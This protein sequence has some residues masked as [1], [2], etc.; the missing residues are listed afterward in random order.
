MIV[1]L[2]A[3]VVLATILMCHSVL[4]TYHGYASE[5]CSGDIIRFESWKD[6]TESVCPK[7]RSY[8]W[9]KDESELKDLRC[10]AMHSMEN[11]TVTADPL[12]LDEILFE[13]PDWFFDTGYAW[14]PNWKWSIEDAESR[15]H[16]FEQCLRSKITDLLTD[17]KRIGLMSKDLRATLEKIDEAT[18]DLV[19]GRPGGMGIGGFYSYDPPTIHI[20]VFGIIYGYRTS[21]LSPTALLVQI[22]LHEMF[23]A[24]RRQGG[25]AE[26]D[27]DSEE[28]AVWGLTHEAYLLLFGGKEPPQSDEE[29]RNNGQFD[30][31]KDSLTGSDLCQ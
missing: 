13:P 20:N 30:K 19:V 21:R 12:S 18:Y 25:L 23:H 17:K 16:D 6:L 22:I 27:R 14:S 3:T 4:A 15:V 8:K 11:L 1:I 7:I 31:A 24:S 9:T 5:N 2:K 26:G 29:G 28:E 10:Q